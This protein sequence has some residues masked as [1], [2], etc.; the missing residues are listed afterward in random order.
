M[1]NENTNYDLTPENFS[2]IQSLVTST[3]QQLK[4]EKGWP[5]GYAIYVAYDQVGASLKPPREG[6][7]VASFLG[8][9]R[10]AIGLEKQRA[11]NGSQNVPPDEVK[12]DE[13]RP[14][15]PTKDE[16]ARVT[17]IPPHIAVKLREEI[18]G[19]SSGSTRSNS[20][21][22]RMRDDIKGLHV[23]EI[24]LILFPDK[25]SAQRAQLAIHGAA[26]GAWYPKG[27][28]PDGSYR[29]KAKSNANGKGWTL[30]IE[31]LK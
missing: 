18:F 5:F 22:G 26:D 30:N 24:E 10:G 7:E 4:K 3:A 6:N 19:S 1:E 27:Q 25:E 8:T 14:S 12:P 31:R 29:S 21:Q 23:G 17:I 28:L 9:E 15:K 11:Q 13:M 16:P 2:A 20:V